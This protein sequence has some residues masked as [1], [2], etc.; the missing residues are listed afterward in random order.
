MIFLTALL[1]SFVA[2]A[3][4]APRVPTKIL[5][6]LVNQAP[7][8]F[9]ATPKVEVSFLEGTTK[10]ILLSE[11]GGEFDFSKEVN[12]G[13]HQF[14]RLKFLFDHSPEYTKSIRVFYISHF[15]PVSSSGLVFGADCNTAYELSRHFRESGRFFKEGI[16]LSAVPFRYLNTVGGDWYFAFESDGETYI[17][18][19]RVTDSKANIVRCKESEK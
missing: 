15:K 3:D 6:K 18:M 2:E 12:F 9:Y 8:F 19:V 17:S 1:L 16:E 4:F 14:F 10:S 11:G 7:R 13:K 5:D